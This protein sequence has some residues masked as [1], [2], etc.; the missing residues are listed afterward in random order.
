MEIEAKVT[1]QACT[2]KITSIRALTAS[3]DFPAGIE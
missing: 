1:M 2:R 3:I